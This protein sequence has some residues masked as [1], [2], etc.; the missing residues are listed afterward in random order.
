MKNK[1]K[2]KTECT[3][4]VS[5]GGGKTLTGGFGVK[6]IYS[7]EGEGRKLLTAGPNRA[8]VKIMRIRF[9]SLWGLG[10][11]DVLSFDWELNRYAG[12]FSITLLN[13]MVDI[14]W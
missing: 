1:L 8:Q 10:G 2:T 5:V 3:G 7:S 13:F 4:G 6:G 9:K 12:F 14:Y 11:L